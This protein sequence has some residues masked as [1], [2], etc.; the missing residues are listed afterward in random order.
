MKKFVVSFISVLAALWVIDRMGGLLMEQC[1]A[2]TNA[3]PEVKLEHMVKAV[4]DDIVLMGT[5]RCDCHYVPSI[6][7]DSL[8]A[9]VY[10]GGI[11]DTENIFSHYILLNLMLAHHTPKLVCLEVMD[12]DI[13][14][15]AAPFS[16]I[17]FFAPYI[18]INDRSDSVYME[19][20]TYWRYKVSHLYRFN[21]KGVE[22]IGG[23]FVNHRYGEDHGF[24]PLK[25][26]PGN[27][28]ALGEENGLNGV[29]SLKL[30]YV[31]RF[32]DVCKK[33]GIRLVFMISPRYATVDSTRYN[34]L[35]KIAKEN[36]VPLLDY[37][38]KGLFLDH[39]EYF[40]DSGHLWEEGARAYT[41]IFANDLK[42][43][44]S[45]PTLSVIQKEDNE[46]NVNKYY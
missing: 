27:P 9:S 37:H 19:A 20:G 39:P 14:I 45:S 43:V 8:H 29:D 36:G 31:N 4:N 12:K 1:M 15:S 3:K 18:N 44:L 6:L 17:S 10:N 2:H 13:S 46:T 33:N 30:S 5:S 21:A 38:T 40:K 26:T 32:I 42:R 25:R 23:L 35:K 28:P 7:M 24:F 16:K 22:A 41:S 11:A 34:P